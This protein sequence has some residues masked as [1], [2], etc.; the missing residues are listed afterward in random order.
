MNI[1]EGLKFLPSDSIDCIVTSPPYWALRE[2]G[3]E[4]QIW[5]GNPECE[6]QWGSKNKSFQRLRSGIGSTTGKVGFSETLHPSTGCFCTKCDG[7][8]GELGLEPTFDLCIKQ[9]C[10]IFDE[11]KRVLKKTGT[12]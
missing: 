5:E 2:Y 8:K 7:W 3:F 11:I 12:C 9:L 6:H 4:P 10:C 1:M